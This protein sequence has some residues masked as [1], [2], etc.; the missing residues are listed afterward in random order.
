MVYYKKVNGDLLNDFRTMRQ[1][2]TTSVVHNPQLEKRGKIKS[3]PLS[4]H[5]PDYK[6]SMREKMENINDHIDSFKAYD[7][8][9][10]FAI[11]AEDHHSRYVIS[12][13][14]DCGAMKKLQSNFTNEEICIMIEF[15][16]E[17][18]QDYLLPVETLRPTVLISGWQGTIFY[19][20]Q[21]WLDDKYTP[22]KKTSKNPVREWSEEVPNGNNA[23]IG[24]WKL[25]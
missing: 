5:V 24:E 4:D 15:L 9:L 13:G 25:L 20:S 22:K 23:T 19:D 2:I 21:L 14:R 3:K 18:D 17:S 11:K 7:L 6:Q 12:R 10:F 8:V 1:Q 16:F